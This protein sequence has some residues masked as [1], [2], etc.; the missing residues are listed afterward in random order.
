MATSSESSSLS[1]LQDRL[2]KSEVGRAEAEENMMRAAR[3]GQ[4]LLDRVR[5]LEDD[6]D[7]ERQSRHDAEVRLNAATA[8]EA[9]AREEMSALRATVAALESRAETTAALLKDNDDLR[10]AADEAAKRERAAEEKIAL[11]EEQLAE[12]NK[13]AL[14]VSSA[15]LKDVS[16]NGS[17]VN[18]AEEELAALQVKL[19]LPIPSS[20]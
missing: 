1:D 6:L 14:D 10:S 13:L 18:A 8:S 12:A 20:R 17:A 3:A 5:S 15:N 19:P 9:A 2:K 7:D 4:D 11:L 16:I